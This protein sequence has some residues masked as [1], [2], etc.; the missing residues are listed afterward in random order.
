M[1]MLFL[2][3]FC[4][5]DDMYVRQFTSIETTEYSRCICERP[6][7]KHLEPPN[8]DNKNKDII[9]YPHYTLP[10]R[11]VPQRSIRRS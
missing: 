8:N 4:L 1:L 5:A 10:L 9:I 2:N 3:Y 6:P 7:R 11:H